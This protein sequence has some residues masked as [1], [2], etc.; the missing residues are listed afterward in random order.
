MGVGTAICIDLGRPGKSSGVIEG[1]FDVDYQNSKVRRKIQ[2]FRNFRKITK[3][4]EMIGNDQKSV[5]EDHLG[6]GMVICILMF[7][8]Y[9]EEAAKVRQTTFF[10]HA[11]LFITCS[12]I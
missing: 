3:Y 6:V 12:D 5:W 10:Q 2:K 11:L 8:L 1:D 9:C 4:H 7:V